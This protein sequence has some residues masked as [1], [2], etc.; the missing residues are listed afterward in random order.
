MKNSQYY[1]LD[2]LRLAEALWRG[3][4]ILILS[5]ILF[6]GAGFGLSA[7]LIPPKYEA[8]AL[9][10][11]NNSSASLGNTSFSISSSELTA[12]QSLAD[13]YIIILKTRSTLNEV[14]EKEKLD[15]T[16]EELY[17]MVSSEP[18][19]NTEVFSIRVTSKNAV[20]AKRIAN[21]IAE[22]LP[23]KISEVVDGSSVHVV[24][25]AVVPQEQ[26][27]P[28][29]IKFTAFGFLAGLLLVSMIIVIR[30]MLDTLIHD[31]EYLIQTYHLP[32]LA[33]I[34]DHTRSGPMTKY[35]KANCSI[36]NTKENE[37]C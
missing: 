17:K 35:Y 27:S 5:G 22:I 33:I 7:C 29:I 25:Y 4:W 15:Y 37:S 30:T 8:E 6:A 19:N 20:E 14:I 23:G 24:D 3:A 26:V 13:T 16:Y 36:G 9:M 12:A 1:E 21:A 11:V 18:V 31:E 32:V 28:N 2:I 34:P 10:Y